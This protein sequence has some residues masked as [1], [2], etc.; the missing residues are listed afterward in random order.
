MV[1]VNR[2]LRVR[3]A[4]KLVRQS[5]LIKMKISSGVFV[6]IYMYLANHMLLKTLE[7]VEVDTLIQ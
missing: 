6:Q 1:Q 5:F 3:L 4:L 2:Q 7:R